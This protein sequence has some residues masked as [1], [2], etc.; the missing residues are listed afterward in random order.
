MPAAII[1]GR[2]ILQRSERFK[3]SDIARSAK[4]LSLALATPQPR[5]IASPTK[6]I[7]LRLYST[8][9]TDHKADAES[10][11]KRNP[12]PDFKKVEG[13]R[14]DFN[15]SQNTPIFTKTK[16]TNWKPGQG[17]NDG[18]ESIKK[19]HVEIDPYAEGRPAVYNY[20]LLISAITPRFIGFVST[21][22]KD[23]KK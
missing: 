11:V 21:R 9:M 13:S 18:G 4:V 12:H 20:K 15:S 14:P 10:Q 19:N 17:A 6:N 5:S 1:N 22:S 2:T 3:K 23:G 16:D 8:K 7:N